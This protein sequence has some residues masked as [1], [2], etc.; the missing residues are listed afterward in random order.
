MTRQIIEGTA[1]ETI[2]MTLKVW[3][4]GEHGGQANTRFA[5]GF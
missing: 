3:E 1:I 4:V 5:G 2:A